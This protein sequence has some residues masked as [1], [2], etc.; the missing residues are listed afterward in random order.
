MKLKKEG[1]EGK[2]R[3][4]DKR[5]HRRRQSTSQMTSVSLSRTIKLLL[6]C[7]CYLSL[8]THFIKAGG[9]GKGKL[10]K[11]SFLDSAARFHIA[12]NPH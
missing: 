5:N 6:I 1:L 11:A 10:I 2:K 7:I 4:I 3:R 12:H 8:A 9:K